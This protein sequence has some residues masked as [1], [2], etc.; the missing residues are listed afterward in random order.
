MGETRKHTQ[1]PYKCRKGRD[2]VANSDRPKGK[3]KVS[4]LQA[5]V[6]PRGWVEV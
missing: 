1:L 5:S 4:P 6:W 2:F 3:G